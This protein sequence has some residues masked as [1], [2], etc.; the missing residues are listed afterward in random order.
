MDPVKRKDGRYAARVFTLQPDGSRKPKWVYDRDYAECIRKRDELLSKV[1]DAIPVPSR[2]STLAE[3]LD[4]W[5]EEIIL[6]GRPYT[7]YARYEGDSR[8]Y[9]RPRLGS[10]RLQALSVADVR[11][12]RNDLIR[13]KGPG[14]AKSVLVALRSALNA[15]MEEEVIARNVARLVDL[16]DPEYVEP[17][18]WSADEAAEFL[19]GVQR[20]RMAAAWL[21]L[22]ILGLRRAEVRALR[23]SDIDWEAHTIRVHRQSQRLSVPG[24]ERTEVEYR[25]KGRGRKKNEGRI[26]VPDF[27]VD[28]LVRQRIR[29]GEQ[30]RRSGERWQD[31]GLV[32]TGHHGRPLDPS[33][34]HKMFLRQSS[35]LGLRRVRLHDARH[36]ASS[37]LARMGAQPHVVQTIMGHTNVQT[38]FGVYVHTEWDEQREALERV[39]SRL[40]GTAAVSD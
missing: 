14:V 10:R 37:L 2:S 9:L 5:L 24:R 8:L 33:A 30:R 4:Y 25:V 3:W 26:G 20:H 6:K 28:A 36:G 23:W 29:Q 16:P 22:L 40:F 32:F 31:H 11:S 34:L 13:A 27:I 38:T 7:T 17:Q 21:L 1:R 12:L 35:R 39:G 18:P 19:R 15:A